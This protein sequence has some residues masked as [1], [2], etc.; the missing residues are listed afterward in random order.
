V[1][2]HVIGFHDVLILRPLDAK[3]KRPG[4]DPAARWSLTVAALS[5]ALRRTHEGLSPPDTDMPDVDLRHLLP[6][7][8]TDVLVHTWDL[9]QA[10]GCDAALDPA[11]SEAAYV[12]ARQNEER[13]RAS[14][15]FAPS[16]R[17]SE[18]EDIETKLVAFLGRD[19][20]WNASLG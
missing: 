12:R 13:L 15:M 9:A 17:V 8:T 19:P 1:V 7:L 6:M 3:P 5:L 2:E 18:D 4:E 16:V 20:G 11:L 14:G 10:I